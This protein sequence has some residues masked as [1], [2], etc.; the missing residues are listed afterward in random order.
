MCFNEIYTHRWC[1][2]SHLMF[3]QEYLASHASMER[4]FP[5]FS[6]FFQ[7]VDINLLSIYCQLRESITRA[8][9]KYCLFILTVTLCLYVTFQMKMS[10]RLSIERQRLTMA[11]PT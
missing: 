8:C 7:I 9:E 10:D 5:F 1:W 6:F 3:L 11:L 4:M 2:N